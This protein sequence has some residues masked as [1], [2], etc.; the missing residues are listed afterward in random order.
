MTRPSSPPAI[1]L[2]LLRLLSASLPVGAFAYSRGLEHAVAAEWVRDAE[3]LKDWVF[4]VLEHSFTTLDGALFLRL[5]AALKV[6]DMQAFK[7]ADDWLSAARES[8]E[9]QQ[10][11]QR[12]AESL[13]VLLKDLGVALVAEAGLDPVCRSYP[14][15]YAIAASDLEVPAEPA[16]AGLMWA[17]C[18]VQIA[19]AIRLGCIGQTEGQRILSAAPGVITHCVDKASRLPDS[20]IGNVSLLMAIGSARH[21]VQNSRLFRS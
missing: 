3:G 17:L 10:E 1:P 8:R 5:M 21:E 9:L 7:R 20:E 6:A 15:A 4:G 13:L 16:L 12:T 14:A 18:D 19:S 11:D 2:P